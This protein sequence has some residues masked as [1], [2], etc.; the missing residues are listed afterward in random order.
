[1]PPVEADRTFYEQFMLI[2]HGFHNGTLQKREMDAWKAGQ[3]RKVLNLAV[4]GSPFYSKHLEGIDL[5]A[6]TPD[7]LSALPFT[8]KNDLNEQMLDM[9]SADY[10]DSTFYFLTSGT[11]GR[12]TPCPRGVREILASNFNAAMSIKKIVN[13]CEG[14]PEKP[15]FAVLCPNELTAACKT[16]TDVCRDLGMLVIDAWPGNPKI[17]WKACIDVLKDLD[18]NIIIASSGFFPSLAK[19]ARKCGYDPRTDFGIKVILSLGEVLSEPMKANIG[20]LWNAEVYDFVYGSQESFIMAAAD[21]AGNLVPHLPNYIWEIID[22]VTGVSSS[23]GHGELCLTSLIDGIKPLIRY[24]IGDLVDLELDEDRPIAATSRL[25]IHGR[26]RDKIAIGPSRVT[27]L[28][29][30]ELAVAG[31]HDC[32]GYQYRLQGRED[33]QHVRLELEM[34]SDDPSEQNI[35]TAALAERVTARLQVPCEVEIIES[36][37]AHARLGSCVTWKA[38]RIIDEREMVGPERE[39][40]E[41]E[42]AKAKAMI[43]SMPDL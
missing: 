16:Y 5:N 34:M 27:A 39:A 38:A 9:A 22:P 20:S 33:Y 21:Q 37:E 42:V 25:R 23:N 15:V 11:T 36:L 17:G 29:L 35:D 26:T 31:I 32:V 4:D 18:V 24:R 8:T 13:D 14:M 10:R 40:Y 12:P 3:L 2:G 1:M 6:I 43:A 19:A 41:K 30:D 28:E 7:D